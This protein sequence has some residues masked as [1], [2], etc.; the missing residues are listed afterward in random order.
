MLYSINWPNFIVWLP[1]L[2]EILD[3]LYTYCNYCNT[4]IT[5]ICCPVCDT[6]N[7]EIY[8]SFLIKPLLYIIK[9]SGQ[10]FKYLKNDKSFSHKIKS[11][12]H[13]LK[14]FSLKKIKITFLEGEGPALSNSNFPC[15]DNRHFW[16]FL[17]SLTHFLQ[18]INSKL[19]L[20]CVYFSSPS[21][22]YFARVV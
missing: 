3:I 9:K 13:H 19:A 6:I 5:V 7:F 11:I 12:F 1:L 2:L 21:Q 22:V 10:K 4:H 18:L 17:S 15:R 8:L 16:W 20:H 14:R